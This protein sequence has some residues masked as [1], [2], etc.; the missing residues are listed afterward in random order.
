MLSA[1]S[2]AVSGLGFGPVQVAASGL[3]PVI[4]VV[5]PPVLVG[6]G[7][8]PVYRAAGTPKKRDT[9]DGIARH[10]AQLVQVVTAL[11]TSGLLDHLQLE[12][13]ILQFR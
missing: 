10:N 6:L 3:L 11:L 2:V 4:D 5:L 1:R 9:V 7:Q 13:C 8:N 12:G